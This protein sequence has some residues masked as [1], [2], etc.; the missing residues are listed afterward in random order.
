MR[1]ILDVLIVDE[2]FNNIQAL[3]FYKFIELTAGLSD[4]MQS[5]GL[6]C[7]LLGE[8]YL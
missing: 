2:S 8:V 4:G 7:F 1:F 3:F 6:I 5:D